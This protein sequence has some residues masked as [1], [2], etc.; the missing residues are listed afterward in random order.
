MDGGSSI[1][2]FLVCDGAEEQAVSVDEMPEHDAWVDCALVFRK[3]DGLIFPCEGNIVFELVEQDI[4]ERI[5]FDV[6]RS[7]DFIW[8]Q[9]LVKFCE[10]FHVV[11]EH[12][13][14]GI[15]VLPVRHVVTSC[16]YFTM[17]FDGLQEKCGSSR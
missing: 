3:N 14:D 10:F 8:P 6:V 11:H 7:D 5:D 2:S 4:I 16:L 15:F 13:E 17:I 9:G 12:A 1:K